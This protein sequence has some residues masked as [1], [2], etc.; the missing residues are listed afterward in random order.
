MSSSIEQYFNEAQAVAQVLSGYVERYTPNGSEPA[1]RPDEEEFTA[2]WQG[3]ELLARATSY[4]HA[5][6]AAEQARLYLALPVPQ[7]QKG[8]LYGPSGEP[9]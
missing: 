5:Q 9:L 2:I 8:T 1:P 4:I 6:I 3:V 7:E